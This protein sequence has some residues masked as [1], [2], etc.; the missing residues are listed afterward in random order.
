MKYVG[1]I[2]ELD[3]LSFAMGFKSCFTN[4]YRDNSDVVE[5]LENG[6]AFASWMDYVS[7]VENIEILIALFEYFTDGEWIW[8]VYFSYYLRKYKNFYIPIEFIEY[9][10]RNKEK[11]IHFTDKELVEFETDFFRERKQY[12]E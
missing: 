1:F 7:E 3:K 12:E 11:Q 4:I 9:V 10:I 6:V 2:K 8:P 5:Y